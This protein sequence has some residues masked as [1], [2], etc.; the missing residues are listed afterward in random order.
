MLDARTAYLETHIKT[1]APQKLRLMLIEAAIRFAQQAREAGGGELFS[2]G[3][4]R[5][6][7]VVTELIAGIRPEKQSLNDTVR[8]LYVFV[9]R[10]LSE[11]QL[12]HNLSKIEDAL[13]V[14]EEEQQTWLQVCEQMPETQLSDF[15]PQE[16][17]AVDCQPTAVGSFS[18]DA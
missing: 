2:S 15:R 17:V 7:D 5:A 8:A 11:A 13:K 14:L 1:A 3:L 4:E 12:L 16:I 10:S 9:F 6:R 18:L